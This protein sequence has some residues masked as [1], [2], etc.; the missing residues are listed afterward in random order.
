MTRLQASACLIV[1]FLVGRW[2]LIISRGH[3]AL[4]LF[5]GVNSF[6]S[7]WLAREGLRVSYRSAEGDVARLGTL[8]TL[9][10]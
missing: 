4:A 6:L 5:P 9:I 3:G 1:W 7:G 8:R 2:G 10:I